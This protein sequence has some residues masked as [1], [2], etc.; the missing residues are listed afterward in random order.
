MRFKTINEM[1]EIFRQ[2]D[3]ETAINRSF[4]QRLIDD[5]KVPYEK[6]G[7]RM[8][9]DYDS[10]LMKLNIM[11]G[12]GPFLKF[13]HVRSIDGTILALKKQKQEIGIGEDKLRKLISAGMVP[14]IQI[15][16]RNYLAMEMFD[17]PHDRLF[18]VD[19]YSF[20]DS[21]PCQSRRRR[22]SD[23]QFSELIKRSTKRAVICRI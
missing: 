4:I 6:H 19:G 23:E 20:K 9:C 3:P 16:N 13:V 7:N 14:T 18:C 1:V 22:Y 17:P 8:V 12:L 2:T 15:G 5:G 11:L 10:L 21:V